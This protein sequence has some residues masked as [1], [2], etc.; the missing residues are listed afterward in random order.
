MINLTQWR[1]FLRPITLN[2]I[3][4]HTSSIPQ[5]R[6]HQVQMPYNFPTVHTTNRSKVKRIRKCR[7]E[8]RINRTKRMGTAI[9]WAFSLDISN[10]AGIP[11]ITVSLWILRRLR[12]CAVLSTSILQVQ[13]LNVLQNAKLVSVQNCVDK[14]GSTRQS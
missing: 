10:E 14:Q 2:N 3:T 7:K 13:M 8:Q 4:I 1:Y 5:S 9:K 6:I 11:E 12:S